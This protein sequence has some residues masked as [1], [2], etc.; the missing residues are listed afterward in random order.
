MQKIAE[1]FFPPFPLPIPLFPRQF[2]FPL[3]PFPYPQFPLMHLISFPSSTN[4]PSVTN[5]PS[6]SWPSPKHKTVHSIHT[7]GPPV[8]AHA[9]PLSTAQLAFAE[10][11]FK[12]L[13]SLW[14]VRLSSS[15]WATPLHM[16]PKSNGG[17]RPCVDYRQLNNVTIPDKYPLPNMQ[18]LSS[19]LHDA[20]VFS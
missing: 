17:W 19:F 1:S 9:R 2:P 20:K 5:P 10:K 6:T 13:E 7:S 3:F 8:L 16:V 18:G 4:F 11:T 15:P 14:I 12:E